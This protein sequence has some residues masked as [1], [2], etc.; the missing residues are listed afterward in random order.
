[1]E[2]TEFLVWVASGLGATSVFSYI[3]ERWAW[4]QGLTSDT[5]KLVSTISASVL[6][7]LAYVTV[8]YV[9]AEVWVM[10]SP[11]W[12]IIVGVVMI[13]YGTQVFHKYDKGLLSA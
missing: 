3:A 1:M 10:L 4:F 9:P 8:T 2:I 5:K 6:A 11:Y 12:Q 13:N 7:I